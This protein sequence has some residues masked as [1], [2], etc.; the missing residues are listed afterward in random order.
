MRR[1]EIYKKEV[2]R[3]FGGFFL[4]AIGA[5]VFLLSLLV[6]EIGLEGSFKVGI[7]AGPA[8]AVAAEDQGAFEMQGVENESR[9]RRGRAIGEA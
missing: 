3:R 2:L 7:T 8:T 1:K 5:T 9:D 6:Q 4:F